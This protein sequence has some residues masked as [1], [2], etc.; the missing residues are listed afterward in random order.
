MDQFVWAAKNIH[1]IDRRK[2]RE[3]AENNFSLE[4]I[5][6]MYEE[7]F[8]SLLPI[9]TGKGFYEINDKRKDLDWMKREYPSSK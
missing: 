8:S 2:C 5:A 7:Y 9:F 3:W 4:H 1:K 6:P